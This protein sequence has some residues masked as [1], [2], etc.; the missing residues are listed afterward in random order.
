MITRRLNIKE[1]NRSRAIS[2]VSPDDFSY[3]P[4]PEIAPDLILADPRFS[5]YC[6]DPI[7]NAA[8]FAECEDPSAVDRA[9]FYYQGQAEHAIGLASMPLE[10][11]HRV[12]RQLPIEQ[13]RI[14]FVHSVGRCGSTLLSKVLQAVPSVHS[15]SEPDDLTQ[16]GNLRVTGTLT[17][18]EICDLLSS[19]IRWRFKART[20]E[21]AQFLAVKPR[22]EV[23]GL[24]D[25]LGP[26]FPEAKHFFLYRNG[27]AWMRSL[28]RGFSAD[29]DV[30]DVEKN[31]EMA[32]SWARNVP[33][34]REFIS[35]GASLNPVQI[36]ILAWISCTEAYLGLAEMPIPTCA[37]KF[38]DLTAHPV[39]VLKQFLE[40]CEISDLDWP[41]IEE[42][43][44]R[45]SQAGSIYDREERRKLTRELTDDLVQD[46]YDMI[47]ARPSLRN[48]EVTL[49]GTITVP[50]VTR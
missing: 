2:I 17:D 15:L 45:D 13:E 28:F 1:N 31:R 4:G 19:S 24:A 6:F 39:P 37:A 22:S 46:V 9:V 21:P 50:W 12:A 27:L 7:N 11:F 32:Q 41:A 44:G 29:R 10:I 30:Y 26:L 14:I 40:F 16:I 20:G 5:L 49:P 38:E 35:D 36:R 18:A 42:V 43:L 48:P 33:L 3:E 25:L 47:A 23:M 8:I 34:V